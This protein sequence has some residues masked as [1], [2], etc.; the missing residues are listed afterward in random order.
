MNNRE[1]IEDFALI[2]Q[3]FEFVHIFWNLLQKENIFIPT[4]VFGVELIF[5]IAGYSLWV[6]FLFEKFFFY[7]FLSDPFS[8]RYNHVC[9][10]SC[11]FVLAN[12][13]TAKMCVHLKIID[14][15]LYAV[16]HNL[17]TKPMWILANARTDC[18]RCTIVS[19]SH[20]FSQIQWIRR[21]TL[22][23]LGCYVSPFYLH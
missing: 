1:S 20:I 13:L 17:I 3:H 9:V 6:I 22:K 21:I 14:W 2:A 12:I 8:L 15:D 11:Y 23:H 4:T 5:N 18:R 10:F 7:R 16:R 19:F